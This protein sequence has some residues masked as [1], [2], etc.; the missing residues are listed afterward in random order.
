MNQEETQTTKQSEQS[1]EE[2]VSQGEE[3]GVESGEELSHEQLLLTLQDA[4]TK[5]DQYWNQLLLARAEV[6]NTRRRSERDVEN[7]HKYALEKFVRELL[8]VKDSLELGLAAAAGEGS[9]LE[10]LRE[11]MELTLKMLGAAMEKFGVSEVDPKGEKFNPELHQAMAMQESPN[12]EPNSVL[13][14]YQK[15]Y[16]LNERLIR[17]A[18][19]VVASSPAEK[20]G[21]S[22]DEKA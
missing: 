9:E 20:K 4:K 6:D 18:M 17:P 13:T 7:A 22:V 11:G 3:S 14:V 15:G 2:T 10:K 8:P 21:P 19:V 16:V 5:A 12:S 1:R